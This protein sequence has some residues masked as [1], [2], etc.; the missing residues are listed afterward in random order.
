[1]PN[2]REFRLP[3]V[4]TILDALPKYLGWW[5]YEMGLAEG[6]RLAPEAGEKNRKEFYEYVKG[7]GREGLATTPN[8]TLDEAADRGTDVHDFAEKYLKGED[9]P[10]ASINPDHRG[11]IDSFLAWW[12]KYKGE[13]IA[14]EVCVYSL[15]HRYAGT[16]DAIIKYPDTAGLFP[17]YM[18]WDFKTSKDV[19]ANHQLQSVAYLQAAIERGYIPEDA[20]VGAGVVSL[21]KSGKPKTVLVDINQCTV[22]V[23]L[24]VKDTWEW[25]QKMG[26]GE[27][28]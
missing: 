20:T 27:W 3:S 8:T 18:V 15:E 11:Y 6:R 26:A 17:E 24:R 1:M 5:G 23:F 25:L 19:Y 9:I 22:D 28:K 2:G 21:R 12:E 4:T 14:S 13:V 7:L 16:L 10:E